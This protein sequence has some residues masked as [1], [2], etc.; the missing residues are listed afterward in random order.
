M[1]ACLSFGTF[2]GLFNGEIPEGMSELFHILIELFHVFQRNHQ[3]YFIFF[4]E[5]T[6]TISY[7][8]RNHQNYFIF[9]KEAT[10]TISYFSKKSLELFHIFQRNHQ[11]YVIFPKK[12]LELFRIFQRNRKDKSITQKKQQLCHTPHN[13]QRN[14]FAISY[15]TTPKNI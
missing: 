1:K 5:T 11:N 15:F 9:F 12:S 14:K 7:F 6:R 3:T 4:K 10:R 13:K 2:I 8:Q